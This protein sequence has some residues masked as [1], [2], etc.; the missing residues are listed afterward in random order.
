MSS[1]HITFRRVRM[2]PWPTRASTCVSA[3]R[4]RGRYVSRLLLRVIGWRC[5]FTEK[6]RP[7]L[8]AEIEPQIL[9]RTMP[10]RITSTATNSDGSG[11]IFTRNPGRAGYRVVTY[12][13]FSANG[14]TVRRERLSDDTYPTMDRILQVG[15]E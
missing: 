3:T 5:A 2:P 15:Q 14:Q 4:F 1:R 10:S 13:V 11:R 8:Q 12:R 6:K 9:S 7:E